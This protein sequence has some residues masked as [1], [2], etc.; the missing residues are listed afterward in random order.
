MKCSSDDII[1]DLIHRGKWDPPVPA[2]K[3]YVAGPMRGIPYF[4]FPAFNAAA[5]HLRE[6]GYV[7]FNPAERDTERHGTDVSAGNV[8]GD[9]KQA[10]R[11]H[12]FSLRV[13]LGEDLAWI[14]AHADM[15]ALLPGWERSKG[16]IAERATAL[17]LGLEVMELA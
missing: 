1:A 5:A 6:Y 9:E 3:V 12:G 8:K 10:E 2:K 17:A 4:N 16:A 15:I 13:A 14:C 11:E 7:V